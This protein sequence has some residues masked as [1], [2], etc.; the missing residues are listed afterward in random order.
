LTH[1]PYDF[2]CYTE[3][4]KVIGKIDN[5][6]FIYFMTEFKPV[7]FFDQPIVPVFDG[8]PRWRRVPIAQAD[9]RGTARWRATCDPHTP[10]PHPRA[11]H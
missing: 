11:G 8:L 5:E 4:K 1:F 9:S 7:H 10:Q 3:Y 6:G 2:V